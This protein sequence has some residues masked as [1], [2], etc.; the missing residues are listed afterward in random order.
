MKI[1]RIDVDGFGTLASLSIK[2]VSP[3]LTVIAGPNEAGKSTLLD[4]IRFMLF[5]FPRTRSASRHEPLRGGRHGGSLRFCDDE[6]AEWTLERH[7]DQKSPVLTG[8]TGQ[9]GGED[10]LRSLLGGADATV[11]RT[12]FAFGLSELVS[13]E[14]LESDEVRD[15]IFTAGVL[16]AGRS[17]TRATRILA[18]RRSELLKPRAR[19]ARANDL[20]HRLD[21]ARRQLQTKRGL[22][23]AFPASVARLRQLEEA[24]SAAAAREDEFTRRRA[25][26]D[27]LLAAWPAWHRLRDA[28]TRLAELGAPPESDGGLLSRTVEIRSLFEERSGYLGRLE[29][30]DTLER[31]RD[32]IENKIR[33]LTTERRERATR[34]DELTRHTRPAS[35]IRAE[36]HHLVTLR[37]LV[38][39]RDQQSAFRAQQ[40]AMR[41]AANAAKRPQVAPWLLATLGLSVVL[42]VVVGLVG[43]LRHQP[44][45]ATL[46]FVAAAVVFATLVVTFRT[47]ARNSIDDG[48]V[49]HALPPLS[50][51]VD[52]LSEEIARL[53]STLR[54]SV[55]PLLSEIEAVSLG[56]DEELQRRQLLDREDERRVDLESELA[57]LDEGRS[58]V[59]AAMES[60]QS[61]ISDFDGRTEAIAFACDFALDEPP[62]TI[63]LRLASALE[64][65]EQ[66]AAERRSLEAEAATFR[67]SLAEA[68]GSGDEADRVR[69]LLSAGDRASWE[70]ERS[71]TIEAIERARSAW[72]TA[73]DEEMAAARALAELESSDEIARL[74][75]EVAALGEELHETLTE[76][77]TL[78]AAHELLRES[79]ERYERERQPAVI[80]K[81]SEL[82]ALVTQGRYER[83]IAREEDRGSAR[84]VV[85]MARNGSLVDAASLSRGT[86]EQLYLCLR[87]GLASVHAERS[88]ALPF[89]L[90]DV[91][92]NFD[93]QRAAAVAD[94]IAQT[95]VSHQ[96]LV[97]TC[98]PHV[99][100][101]LE[102]AAPDRLV[103][104][105]PS[106]AQTG[107]GSRVTR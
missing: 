77:L 75:I 44:L 92:V 32:G 30:F 69:I 26:L 72:Q 74:E 5:G 99:V 4:F 35:E 105:L 14:N 63:C 60:D 54:L 103:V 7:A 90:D 93:P 21:E 37:S 48:A 98:H 61:R 33:V 73:R 18:E 43:A 11:F 71:R 36:Q 65:A 91:L 42:A 84:T 9:I 76:W 82:F 6:G 8:A 68:I 3:Q 100:E 16:G 34:S 79:V 52:R 58:S 107:D 59:L 23:V 2:E 40:E 20:A 39:Q 95:A 101:T 31:Q 67:S 49:T 81:A 62:A 102:K 27:N 64:A 86:A 12:V 57:D 46:A 80:A 106:D 29:K 96:V 53:A 94:V 47:G 51:D 10:E 1:R 28:E 22:A 17:A 88:T 19:S 56:L 78:G 50:V 25:E 83:L 13:L 85:A 41:V 45:L 97:F 89:V 66:R 104:E 24:T 55:T 70:S 38:Q 15:L 87:L